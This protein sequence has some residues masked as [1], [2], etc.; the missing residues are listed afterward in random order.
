MLSTEGFFSLNLFTLQLVEST[1]A[2]L[3]AWGHADMERCYN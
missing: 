1:N 3:M 2:E